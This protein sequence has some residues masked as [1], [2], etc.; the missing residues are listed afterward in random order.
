MH[1][2]THPQFSYSVDP[3]ITPD[4]LRT[5][6]LYGEHFAFAQPSRPYSFASFIMYA[7]ILP[8]QSQILSPRNNIASLIIIFLSMCGF[9][10]NILHREIP[11]YVL[12][13]DSR[14][15]PKTTPLS[16]QKHQESFYPDSL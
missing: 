7:V 11:K 4:G 3:F 13:F 15:F 14:D 1:L 8:S 12:K 9:Y 16:N 6:W 10:M 2:H 5:V